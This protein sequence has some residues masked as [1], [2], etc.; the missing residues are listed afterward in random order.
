MTAQDQHR[1]NEGYVCLK[2]AYDKLVQI[3]HMDNILARTVRTLGA[4][5]DTLYEYIADEEVK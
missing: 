5:Q 1:V 2:E 4:I 3:R